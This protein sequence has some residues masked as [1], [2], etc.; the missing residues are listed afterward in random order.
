MTRPRIAILGRFAEGTTVTRYRG[1]VTAQALAEAVWAAGGEPLTFLPVSNSN[2]SERM[3]GID[4]V[5]MPGGGD[6]D[7]SHYS[8]E[9]MTDEIYG[10]DALQDQADF[11][12]V[13]WAID[14]AIPL[15]AICRGCQ[16]VNVALGG[17]LIQHMADDHRHKVHEVKL[18]AVGELGISGDSVE[19][20]CYHHQAIDE[21]GSGIEVIGTSAD[22]VV[23]AIKIPSKAWA[24]GVQWHPEDNFATNSQQLALFERFVG[25]AASFSSRRQ[26]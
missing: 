9:V 10:V 4:G 15:L 19:V 23:E 14:N 16:L 20:S 2:W 6:L 22:G 21:L 11:E 3:V 7:P 13:K 17:N 25:E 18:G 24:F 8:T 5:L 26:R 1:L 12:L